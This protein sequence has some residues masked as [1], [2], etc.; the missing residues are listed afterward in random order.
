MV[1]S[2]TLIAFS[3]VLLAYQ[4]GLTPQALL[5]IVNKGELSTV[6][7]ELLAA[8]ALPVLS[9]L[10]ALAAATVKRLHD[11]GKSAWWLLTLAVPLVGLV[12]QVGECGFVAGDEGDNRFGADRRAAPA[13][14]A[15]D[16]EP[17]TP[18][19]PSPHRL[20]RAV[21]ASAAKQAHLA[22][23]GRRSYHM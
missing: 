5:A 1:F 13:R 4:H 18:Q 12:W 14:L 21:M 19:G 23:N 17:M 6:R 22:R 8:A 9:A 7:L 20:E 10:W 15:R 11:L 2:T 3:V 16:G